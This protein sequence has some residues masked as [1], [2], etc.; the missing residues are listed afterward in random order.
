MYFAYYLLRM[1]LFS[2][3][4]PLSWFSK[5][6]SFYSKSKSKLCVLLNFSRMFLYFWIDDLRSASSS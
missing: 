6:L 4:V 3:Y 5:V 1:E 2:T